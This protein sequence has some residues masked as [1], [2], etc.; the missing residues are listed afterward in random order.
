MD[1]YMLVIQH[2]GLKV[3]IKIKIWWIFIDDP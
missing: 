1:A 3:N 2:F